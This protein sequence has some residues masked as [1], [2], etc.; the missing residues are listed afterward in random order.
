M[1]HVSH[2]FRELLP[3][4]GLAD[5]LHDYQIQCIGTGQQTKVKHSLKYSEIKTTER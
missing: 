4:T 5:M 1:N 2:A 3:H